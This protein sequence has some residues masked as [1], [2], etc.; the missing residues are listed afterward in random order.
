MTGQLLAQVLVGDHS[1]TLIRE[2]QVV[3]AVCSG[4]QEHWVIPY[5]KFLART[6]PGVTF[7]H[8][9]DCPVIVHG[10]KLFQPTEG[11]H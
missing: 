1:V 9:A 7:T 11:I 2:G 4:C 10:A 6:T 8:G 5:G 3:K